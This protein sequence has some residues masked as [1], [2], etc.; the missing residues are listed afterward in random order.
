MRILDGV[1]LDVIVMDMDT[2]QYFGKWP[3]IH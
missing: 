1:G 2:K 3:D